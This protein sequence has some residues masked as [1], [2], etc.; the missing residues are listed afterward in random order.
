M[1]YRRG[2]RRPSNSEVVLVRTTTPVKMRI[3]LFAGLLLAF[4]GSFVLLVATGI[5]S[6]G[7][8]LGAFLFGL[9]LLL[10]GGVFAIRSVVVMFE[11]YRVVL[12]LRNE[13]R[14][15]LAD[16]HYTTNM[17]EAR[18]LAGHV[19]EMLKDARASQ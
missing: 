17:D 7:G 5:D 6:V 19:E 11:S 8:M 9:L 13:E 4:G 14:V 10:L 12:A 1:P 3:G 18:K 16:Y 2:A 15:P